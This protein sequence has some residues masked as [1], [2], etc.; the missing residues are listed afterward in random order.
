MIN[1]VINHGDGTLVLELP[2]N[3][4]GIHEKLMSM[5][6]SGGPHRVP[7]TDNEGDALRVKLYGADDTGNH[8]LRL[9][10]EQNTLADANTMAFVVQNASADI[11]EKLTEKIA[12]DRYDSLPELVADIRQMT[13]DAGPIKQTYYCPLTAE[14]VDEDDYS[15]AV[16]NRFL[17]DYAEMI[18]EAVDQERDRD[19]QDMAEYYHGDDGL[20]SKL[21][22]MVWGVELYRGRLFGKI[23]CSF[24]E[25]LTPAEEKRRYSAGADGSW[26]L[27]YVF[28]PQRLCRRLQS[29]VQAGRCYLPDG[30]FADNA[31]VPRTSDL[32]GSHAYGSWHS[33]R[34]KRG[35][36]NCPAVRP[37]QLCQGQHDVCR[38][39]DYH[40]GQPD[41]FS[42]SR[43]VRTA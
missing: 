31:A 5:G 13:Y 3:I 1:A 4:Y 12:A 18:R 11:K 24:K 32:P 2:H 21:A 35:A 29:V 36:S 41:P 6:Y 23:E 28:C 19:D 14:L 43:K 39:C 34:S 15:S 30:V 37:R 25:T 33:S 42:G 27:V 20:K 16:S 40:G 17:R 10:T 9:L 8:L 22:S 7:L 26:K 38:A